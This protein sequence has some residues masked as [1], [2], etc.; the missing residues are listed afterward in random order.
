MELDRKLTKQGARKTM[1]E[2]N[3]GVDNRG[4]KGPKVSATVDLH[5]ES[6][7]KRNSQEVRETSKGKTNG[8]VAVKRNHD[9][10][11]RRS[12]EETPLIMEVKGCLFRERL[13]KRL[14]RK[15]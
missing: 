8:F 4:E 15:A 13:A 6:A 10:K 11:S 3:L 14:G 12:E 9:C 5:E 1:R 2:K 7:P